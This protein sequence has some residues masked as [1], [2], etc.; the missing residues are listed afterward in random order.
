[1]EQPPPLPGQKINEGKG[2][3]FPC[4]ECGADLEFHIGEQSLR[5]PYCST[6]K[7]IVIDDDAEVVEQDFHE[8]IRKL[9]ERK[10]D[11]TTDH[12][13]HCEV[14]CDSCGSNVLF[15]ETLTSTDCPYCGSPLQREKIH[16]GGFRIAVDA[17]LPFK[18]DDRDAKTKIAEWVKSRWFAPNKFKKRGAQGKING[19]YL[20]FWTFDSLTFTVYRG[21]RGEERTETTG[22]GDNKSTRTVTDWYPASGKF[23]RFFDDILIN[24]TRNLSGTH[25]S[26]LNPWPL[27][28]ALPFTQ[29][30]LAGHFARTYDIELEEAFP[31]AKT[32]MDDALLA[33][34]KERIG[35]DKQRVHSIKSRYDAITFK[36]VLLPVHMLAY[37]YHDKTYQVFVNAATGAVHGERPYSWVKITCA[38]L[39]V[40]I[41]CGIIA[42]ATKS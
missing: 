38:V 10:A 9:A 19:V 28:D 2:R 34:T 26:S 8:T 25:V 14:R 30:V 18:I 35:G 32:I 13:E 40:V 7:E 4:D 42:I 24:A 29:E 3:I 27:E 39:A 33:E 41:F 20:P 11:G 31:L 6:V 12:Q 16:R 22:T 37:Q 1:M 5:C 17:V 15:D 23:Q 36:H 21:E